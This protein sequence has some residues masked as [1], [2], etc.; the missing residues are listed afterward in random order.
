MI[1]R[2]II[3]HVK[4][5]EWTAVALD[6]VIVVAGIL[7]AF[8][9]TQWNAERADR[10]KEALY[11][12]ELLD[13]LNA[14]L[15]EINSIKRTA[16]IRMGALEAI[17]ARVG[18]EPRRTLTYDGRTV[19]FDEPPPFHSDDPYEGNTQ[20]T[21]TPELDGSRETFQALIS[22]G[23]LGLIRNRELAR[24]I[25]TY[26]ADMSEVNN[27]EASVNGVATNVN[28]S[29]RRLGVS[30]TGRVTIEDLRTLAASDQQFKAELET[31][32]TGSAYQARAMKQIR[33]DA[34]TL[35]TA[36]EAEQR[37]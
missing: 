3:A 26:Y 32:W 2:R 16:E 1:L 34:E 5:Q 10:K 27:L 36:I 28:D 30:L 18:I 14:D 29:R 22:T 35:I 6:F 37:R 13:D 17:L 12:S 9:I 19:T 24:Q 33:G 15:G 8:Q 31:Y 11:L 23:D 21:N 7:I 20:L 4:K 25:Q